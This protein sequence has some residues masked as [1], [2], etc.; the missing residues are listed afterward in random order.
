MVKFYTLSY[1][2]LGKLK[3][4]IEYICIYRKEKYLFGF[5]KVMHLFICFII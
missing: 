5:L 2:L 4:Q 1:I 3:D